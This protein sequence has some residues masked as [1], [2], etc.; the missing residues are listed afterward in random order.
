V[1]AA[2]LAI[3]LPA[4]VTY[5]DITQ[6]RSPC[7]LEP[8]RWCAFVREAAVDAFPYALAATNT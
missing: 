7:R 3:L 5:P 1:A 4:C 6:S 2:L 8:G